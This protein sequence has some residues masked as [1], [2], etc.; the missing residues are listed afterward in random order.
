MTVLGYLAFLL[1]L[2][3]DGMCLNDDW[4]YLAYRQS[5]GLQTSLYCLRDDP[6]SPKDSFICLWI[7]FVSWYTAKSMFQCK[8]RKGALEVREIVRTQ[9]QITTTDLL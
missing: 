6:Y 1:R 2:E 4:D 3:Q 9:R 7:S 8:E 5:S